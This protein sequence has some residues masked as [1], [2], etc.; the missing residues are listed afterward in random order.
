MS[1]L[2]SGEGRHQWRYSECGGEGFPLR[3]A[4]EGD[5]VHG[6]RTGHVARYPAKRR[7]ARKRYAPVTTF[8]R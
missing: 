7:R 8:L 2:P 5:P 3:A 4:Y 6:R 1:A